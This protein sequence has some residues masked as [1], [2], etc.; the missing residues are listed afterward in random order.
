MDTH[1]EKKGTQISLR[2]PSP[3]SLERLVNL[4]SMARRKHQAPVPGVLDTGET[5]QEVKKACPPSHRA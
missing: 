1:E 2:C 4:L 5:Q 3:S